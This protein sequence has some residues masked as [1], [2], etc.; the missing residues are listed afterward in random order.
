MARSFEMIVLTP[1]GVV[2]PSVA[3]AIAATRAGGL[4]ML[5]FEYAVDPDPAI[6]AIGTVAEAARTTFGIKVSGDAED[7]LA[8]LTARR[9]ERLGVVLLTSRQP[10]VLRRPVKALHERKLTVLLEATCL[11]HARIGELIGVDGIVAKG[12]EAGGRVGE[13]TTFILLQQ[14]LRT[15]SLPVWAHG[16]VVPALRVRDFALSAGVRL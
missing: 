8:G 13:E 5:D 2:E 7:F 6:R 14:L 15:L 1:P 12:N 3:L 10:E 16:A 11:E 9:P 4:G